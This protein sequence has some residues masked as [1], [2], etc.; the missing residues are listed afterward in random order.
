MCLWSFC[1]QFSDLSERTANGTSPKNQER[2]NFNVLQ[3]YSFLYLSCLLST[4]YAIWGGVESDWVHLIIFVLFH[5]QLVEIHDQVITKLTVYPRIQYI[6]SEK[7]VQIRNLLINFPFRSY[8]KQDLL[9]GQATATWLCKLAR[10][11]CWAGHKISEN[12]HLIDLV[13]N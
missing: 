1:L 9:I 4:I 13:E 5:F 7:P 8:P 6:D 3:C 2:V 11:R 12:Y 10:S